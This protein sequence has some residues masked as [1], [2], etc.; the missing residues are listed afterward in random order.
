MLDNHTEENMMK[1]LQTPSRPEDLEAYKRCVCGAEHKLSTMSRKLFSG[2]VNYTER[3]CRD[4]GTQRAE[5]PR[6]VCLGCKTLMGFMEKPSRHASGFRFEKRGTYHIEKCPKCE[7]GRSATPVLE[8]MRYM[9][10]QG[11]C[12]KT[13][14]DLVQEVE[15]KSLQGA[16]EAAKFHRIFN[17]S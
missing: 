10:E 12:V 3:L 16:V 8:L 17:K 15:Q 1:L 11:Q 5:L 13:D 4:C 6:I 2:V 9:K 7:P 14:K